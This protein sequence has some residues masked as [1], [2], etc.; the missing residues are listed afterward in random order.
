MKYKEPGSYP[1]KLLML[2]GG[3]LVG[4]NVLAALAMR[5]EYFQLTVMNS[6]EDEPAIFEY[7]TAYKSPSLIDARV[8]FE[9]RFEEVLSIV[10]PDIIIPCRDEDVAFVAELAQHRPDLRNRLLCGAYDIATAML[11][12][13]LSWEFSKAH[14]LPFAPTIYAN[15][16]KAELLK[17]VKKHG[18]P[19]LAKPRKGFAS[20]GVKL[21]IKEEQLTPLIGC[22][23]YILQK[24][25][26]NPNQVFEYLSQVYEMGVPLFNSFE[27][28]KISIQ[29][30]IGP[31]GE[32]GG[33]FVTEH[34]MSQGKSESVGICKDKEAMA[35]GIQWIEKIANAGWKGPLNIQC[36]RDQEGNLAIYEYNGRFTGATS[37]R[38]YLGFDEV[39]ITL[40]LWLGIKFPK[41]SITQ[42]NETVVR[43]PVSKAVEIDKVNQIRRDGY[44]HALKRTEPIF[45]NIQE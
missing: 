29:G 26:G 34:A 4:Q 23:D 24:Y 45:K 11:D 14:R 42:G 6:K 35:Q 21:L 27:E 1:Y 16:G 40:G 39:G 15:T 43:S 18:L 31:N 3:S 2:S 19:I 28:T 9:K 17:F 44:W 13:G 5:R 10:N 22:P 8:E 30:C 7:D 20:R 36:Q 41:S 12:K 37:G 38:I 25:L 33:V 32:I